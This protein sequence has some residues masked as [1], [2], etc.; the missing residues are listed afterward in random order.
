MPNTTSTPTASSERTRLCAPV[1]PVAGSA[2]DA[3]IERAGVS[4]P[5]RAAAASRAADSLG[6]V[7]IGAS[8]GPDVRVVVRGGCLL[9][10]QKTPR[11]GGTEGSSAS[12]GR[13]AR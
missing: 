2:A 11:A 7:L 3:A 8:P 10:Q 12:V 4:T 9:G 6:V 5:V 1:M 13:P